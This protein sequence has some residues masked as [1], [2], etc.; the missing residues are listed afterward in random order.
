M[1]IV[2]LIVAAFLLAALRLISRSPTRIRFKLSRFLG[3]E[4]EGGGTP[5]RSGE[6][7]PAKELDAAEPGEKRAGDQ[8]V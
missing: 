6:A 7:V 5:S 8:Q 2:L 3:L 1:V 4:I